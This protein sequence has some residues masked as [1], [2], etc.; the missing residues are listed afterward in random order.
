M[1]D[2]DRNN[3]NYI[4]GLTDDQFTEW[5]ES[6]DQEDRAYAVQLIQRY[7]TEQDV[8]LMEIQERLQE[9]TGID[10]SQALEFINRVK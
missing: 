10:C 2:Y 4:I 9:E 3:L 1:N 5:A 8:E 6:L 7:R